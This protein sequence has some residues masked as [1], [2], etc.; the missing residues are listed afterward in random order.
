MHASSCSAL[1][2]ADIHYPIAPVLMLQLVCLLTTLHE[3]VQSPCCPFNTAGLHTD[4]S[5]PFVRYPLPAPRSKKSSSSNCVRRELCAACAC[6]QESS[7]LL[8]L[9]PRWCQGKTM[10]EAG[11]VLK[12]LEEYARKHPG[13]LMRLAAAPRQALA[14]A[15]RH[16]RQPA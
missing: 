4:Y 1:V 10:R 8:V 16:A 3:A 6:A 7:R 12:Q 11:Y 14:A 13:R 9:L 5:A 2:L 15:E